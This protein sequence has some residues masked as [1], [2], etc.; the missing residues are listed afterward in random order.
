MIK[1]IERVD[2]EVTCD[3]CAD[4]VTVVGYRPSTSEG[5]LEGWRDN[6]WQ[7]VMRALD[8]CPACV[9]AVERALAERRAPNVPNERQTD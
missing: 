1:R 3:N 2:L 4:T 8:L 9:R 5:P 6:A 7:S